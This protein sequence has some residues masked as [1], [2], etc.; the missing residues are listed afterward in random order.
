MKNQGA[1]PDDKGPPVREHRR[2][3]NGIGKLAL[4]AHGR[5]AAARGRAAGPAGMQ[6]HAPRECGRAVRHGDPRPRGDGERERHGD[7]HHQAQAPQGEARRDQAGGAGHADGLDRR[8]EE[9][10]GQAVDPRAA[11]SAVK[12]HRK[13]SVKLEA[14]ARTADGAEDQQFATIG[15]LRAAPK[16]KGNR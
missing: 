16:R 6:V 3:M 2:T 8:G 1:H 14:T 15:K 4:A 5:G 13:L 9:R 11:V 10:D 7:D 12:R